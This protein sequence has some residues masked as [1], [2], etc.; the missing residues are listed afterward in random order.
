MTTLGT[1]TVT[2]VAIVVR[3]IEEKARAWAE[4]LGLP[5]PRVIITDPEE[6]AQTRY[7]GQPSTAR[8]KLAFFDLGQVSLELIEPI[9]EPSTWNDQLVQHGESLHHIAFQVDGMARLLP[10]LADDGMPTVQKGEYTGGRYAYVDATARL[11][12]TLEL[13]E[14]DQ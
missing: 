11:G 12:V 5:V 1:T 8:A 2:Q 10:L 9:G 3:D 7:N 4:V 6:I 13:L 14:N